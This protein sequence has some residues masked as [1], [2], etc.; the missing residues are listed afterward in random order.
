MYLNR[1]HTDCKHW[2]D[3]VISY[4]TNASCCTSRT[5]TVVILLHFCFDS[6]SKSCR[7]AVFMR[8]CIRGIKWKETGRSALCVWLSVFSFYLDSHSIDFNKKLYWK[9]LWK[10]IGLFR[11]VHRLISQQSAS[12]KD[13]MC[14]SVSSYRLYEIS[15]AQLGAFRTLRCIERT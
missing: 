1:I 12:I 11:F 8:F 5:H 4:E 9:S 7:V 13:N 3:T 15:S 6:K 14:I 2:K 10:F